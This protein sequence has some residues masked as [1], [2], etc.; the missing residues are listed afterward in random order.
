MVTV[1]AVSAA[2]SAVV[3]VK[4]KTTHIRVTFGRRHG[5]KMLTAMMGMMAAAMVMVA[6][7]YVVGARRVVTVAWAMAVV[8][9]AAASMLKL[10]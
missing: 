5:C 4:M 9:V 2:V 6:P 7:P 1:G 10:S 3:M 8:A